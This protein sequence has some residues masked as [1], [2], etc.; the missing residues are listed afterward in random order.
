[1]GCLCSSNIASQ[2][3]LLKR[4]LS[5]KSRHDTE[6]FSFSASLPTKNFYSQYKLSP[7]P[8]G[9]GLYGEI[10]LCTHIKTEKVYAVKIILKAGLPTDLV[11]HHSIEK[12]FR[13]IQTLDHPCIL[14]IFEFYEDFSNYYLVMEYVNG[15]DLYSKIEK[16]KKFSEETAAKIIKQLL[17]ALAYMHSKNIAHRDIKPENILIEEKNGAMALKLIDFDTC[18]K[19]APST[20]LKGIFGTVYYMAPEVIEGYYNEKCDVWSTGV[21][22]YSLLTKSFPYGG[23][24]DNEIMNNITSSRLNLEILQTDGV[25]AEAIS[26]VKKLLKFNKKKRLTA[27]EASNDLWLLKHTKSIKL[28]PCIAYQKPSFKTSLSQALKL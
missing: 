18:I 22:L 13:L 9:S 1:M 4:S 7:N 11:K 14:K 26:L 3:G 10:R 16:T 2:S 23:H 20:K 17:S 25:S 21:I 24:S 8:L 19:V 27:S 5:Y 12:Q 28:P 15:G 6:D